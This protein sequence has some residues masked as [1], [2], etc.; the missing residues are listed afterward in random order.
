MTTHRWILQPSQKGVLVTLF[1]RHD[2]WG[3][4]G[5]SIVHVPTGLAPRELRGMSI[6]EARVMARFLEEIRLYPRYGFPEH[7]PIDSLS[8]AWRRWRLH[9]LQE[10]DLFFVG[11]L[12]EHEML[13]R[14]RQSASKENDR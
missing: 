10:P 1:D 12:M 5:R 3:Y 8:A 7:C 2:S 14:S 11:D 9:C 13:R 6:Q 4:C